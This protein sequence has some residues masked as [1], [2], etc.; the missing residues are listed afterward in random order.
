MS[1]VDKLN[2]RHLK[3]VCETALIPLFYRARESQRVDA[4]VRDLLAADLIE[5]IDYD[6]SALNPDALD[7]VFA[8]MRTRYFDRS[9]RDFLAEHPNAVVVDIGC[10]LDTRFERLNNGS[11]EWYGVDLPEVIALRRELLHE[12]PRSHFLA[13]SAID[14]AWMHHVYAVS[15]HPFLFLAEGA[16]PYLLEAQVRMLMCALAE[17]F[18]HSELIFDGMSPLFVW[19]HNQQALL[20]RLDL[21]VE[22]GVRNPRDL[23]KW[24]NSIRLVSTWTYFDEPEPRLGRYAWLG[25]VPYLRHANWVARYRLGGARRDI[26]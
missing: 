16:L 13:Y 10:G 8:M 14:F 25:Y 6:F 17:R 12:T 11:M 18:P 23:E 19:L 26:R 22:W 21:R 24:A 1:F 15:P 3:G 7:R 5:Q 20:K 4:I 9:A 2:A